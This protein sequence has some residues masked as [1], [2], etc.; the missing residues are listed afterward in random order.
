MLLRLG[1]F[2]GLLGQN[3]LLKFHLK[4]R[5]S[6][7][8]FGLLK[9]LLELKKLLVDATSISGLLGRPCGRGTLHGRERRL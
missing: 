6:R 3:M 2:L 5:G 9:L 4:L 7:G 8:G 1:G